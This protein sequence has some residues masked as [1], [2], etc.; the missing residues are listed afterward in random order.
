M[1]KFV[2]EYLPFLTVFLSVFLRDF[3][4]AVSVYYAVQEFTGFTAERSAYSQLLDP[5]V[6]IYVDWTLTRAL[7]QSRRAVVTWAI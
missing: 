4:H 2:S 5:F 7:V 1:A 6:E 3:W